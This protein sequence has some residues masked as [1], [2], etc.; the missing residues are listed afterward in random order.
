MFVSFF[1]PFPSDSLLFTYFNKDSFMFL[2]QMKEGHTLQN[3]PQPK[4]AYVTDRAT[5]RAWRN[6]ESNKNHGKQGHTAK[7]YVA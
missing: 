3:L 6:V 1:I 5:Q 2:R 7:N 4:F